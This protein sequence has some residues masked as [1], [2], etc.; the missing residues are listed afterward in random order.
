[1]RNYRIKQK[2][3]VHHFKKKNHSHT[4]N[5]KIL[6]ARQVDRLSDLIMYSLCSSDKTKDIELIL[7]DISIN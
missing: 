5:M 3:H 4:I 1:M 7:F 6:P 2:K